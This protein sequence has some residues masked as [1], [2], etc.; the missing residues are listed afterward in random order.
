[1]SVSVLRI[2]SCAMSY[3]ALN[4]VHFKSGETVFKMK[5]TEIKQVMME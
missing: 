4:A 1:M 5:I 3:L 2:P